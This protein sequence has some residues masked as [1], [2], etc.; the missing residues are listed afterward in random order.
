[1]RTPENRFE[2]ARDL[3]NAAG[4]LAFDEALAARFKAASRTAAE[5]K[6]TAYRVRSTS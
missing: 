2:Q 4:V 6:R 3:G 5:G 1:M